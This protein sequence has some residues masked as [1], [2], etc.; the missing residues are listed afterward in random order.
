MKQSH[1]TLAEGPIQ[2]RG[3]RVS[4]PIHQPWGGACRIVEW[5]DTAGQISRRVVA[6]DVTAA[7][8]RATISRHVEGRKHLLYDD[9]K[10]PRQVLPRQTAMRR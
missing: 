2:V 8:V 7:E 1:E 10:T 6:E 4:A 3:C 5:I 9:E